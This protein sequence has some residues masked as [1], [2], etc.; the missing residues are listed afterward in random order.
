MLLSDIDDHVH[1][2]SH[3]KSE[4]SSFS[5]FHLDKIMREN[6]LMTYN[7]D[8]LKGVFAELNAETVIIDDDRSEKSINFSTKTA[9]N[10]KTPELFTE[11]HKKKMMKEKHA[12]TDSML[13]KRE[14]FELLNMEFVNMNTPR[15]VPKIAY[16]ERFTKK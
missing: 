16:D 4:N 7:T 10:S 1:Y 8:E 2:Y 11:A 14:I 6:K 12:M 3:I 15:D 9:A 5:D 13:K